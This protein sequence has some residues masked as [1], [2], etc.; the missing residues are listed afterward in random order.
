MKKA[1]A[2][3]APAVAKAAPIVSIAV[4][5]AFAIAYAIGSAPLPLHAAGGLREVEPNGSVNQAS[6]IYVNED[7]FGSIANRDDVDYYRFDIPNKGSVTLIFNYYGGVPGHRIR[8]YDGENREL[9]SVSINKPSDIFPYVADR[10]RLPAGTYY[11]RIDRSSNNAFD[12]YC[13]H[14][15]YEDE[16]FGHYENEPNGSVNQADIVTNSVAITGNIESGSDVDYFAFTLGASGSIALTFDY[17]SGIPGHRVRLYDSNNSELLNEYIYTSSTILPYTTP[18]LRVPAGTYYIRVEKFSNNNAYGDYYLSYDYVDESGW[19]YEREP[20]NS[21]NTATP[22]NVNA[23]YTGNIYDGL[24][25]DY[26]SFTVSGYHRASLTFDYRYGTPGHRVRLYD[27]AGKSLLSDT[28]HTS[29]AAL[30]HTTA[31]VDIGPGIYY[32]FVERYGN[33]ADGDY[34]IQANISDGAPSPIATPTPTPMPPNQQPPT[35]IR[36][37][38]PTPPPAS[39]SSSAV[40]GFEARAVG[41]GVKLAWEPLSGGVGYRV[42]RSLS[43]GGSGDSLTDFHIAHNEY[44][45]V[46]VLPNTT[47]YYYIRQVVSGEKTH[48]GVREELGPAT[49]KK[50][51]KTAN[52]VVGGGL[53]PPGGGAAGGSSAAPRKKYIM[54]AI[55]DRYMYVD[56][57]RQ[58]I[59][60]GRGTAPLLHNARTMVPIRAIVEGMGGRVTWREASGEITLDYARHSVRMWLGNYNISVNGEQKTVDVAPMTI[61]DRTMVPIRFAAENLGCAVGWEDATQ[62]IYIV[63]Y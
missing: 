13:I 20:N 51:V 39:A 6:Q 63:Y 62:S 5:L 34:T 21:T 46:N 10:L 15:R 44:V 58:E 19:N 36:T 30:P 54:M 60:P 11:I 16:S 45:D 47:Y 56:G 18:W 7:M 31:A 33:M 12:E 48:D 57:D 27:S 40:S 52:E 32:I 35:P 22:I 24:D 9:F 53:A 14:I 25:K 61:N 43:P 38:T 2:T 37:L 55:D 1:I 26:Y 3:V 59:D 4:L 42:Y 41:A 29:G 17:A 50:M 8:L 49:I 28:I 23:L